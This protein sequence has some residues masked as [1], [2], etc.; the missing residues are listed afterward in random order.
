MHLNIQGCENFESATE[1]NDVLTLLCSISMIVITFLTQLIQRGRRTMQVK[2]SIH[3]HILTS[4]F[5]A[6][7]H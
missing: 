1:S 3:L 2:R 7:I 4:S 5:I 6:S